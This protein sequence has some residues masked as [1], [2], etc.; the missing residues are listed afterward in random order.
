VQVR[1]LSVA[2]EGRGGGRGGWW[3]GGGGGGAVGG[4]SVGGGHGGWIVV[5]WGGGCGVVGIE[6]SASGY[7]TCTQRRCLIRAT[8]TRVKCVSRDYLPFSWHGSTLAMAMRE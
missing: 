2:V 4:G 1:V 5:G 7:P 8:G 6:A 3:R